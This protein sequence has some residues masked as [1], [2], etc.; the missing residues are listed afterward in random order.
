MNA[1]KKLLL[2]IFASCPSLVFAGQHSGLG[3]GTPPAP[4]PE[5]PLSE[6][7]L[8]EYNRWIQEQIEE[9]LK[10]LKSEEK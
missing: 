10:E 6:T 3:S 9:A 1:M 4:T 8:E 7:T 5:A 2:V